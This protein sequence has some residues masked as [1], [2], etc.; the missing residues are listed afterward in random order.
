MAKFAFYILVQG[1]GRH[2][3]DRLTV[4]HIKMLT[5]ISVLI[6]RPSW[7][8]GGRSPIGRHKGDW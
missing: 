7:S 6:G 2:S 8:L 5:G 1:D 3:D 4:T